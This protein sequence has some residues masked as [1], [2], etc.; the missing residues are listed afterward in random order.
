MRVARRLSRFAALVLSV[1]LASSALAG[2][3]NACMPAPGISMQMGAMQA[4]GTAAGVRG[5]APASAHRTAPGHA[6]C[7]LPMTPA[8]CAS[9]APCAP[10]A[11]PSRSIATAAVRP[12]AHRVTDLTIAMTPGDA[13]APELPPPRA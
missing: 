13:R 9:M 7:P 8:A 6:P 1:V 12:I 11:L 10:V 5:H 3:G 4:N 2:P